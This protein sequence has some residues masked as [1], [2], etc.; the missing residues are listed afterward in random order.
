VTTKKK[1]FFYDFRYQVV[2]VV[3]GEVEAE[4]VG[5]AR[6]PRTHRRRSLRLLTV[7]RAVRKVRDATV[8]LVVV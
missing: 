1:R 8:H 6:R 3:D 4:A 7:D 5:G 2:F